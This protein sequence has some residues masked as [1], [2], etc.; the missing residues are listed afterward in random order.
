MTSTRS[1]LVLGLAVLF[2]AAQ[3]PAAAEDSRDGSVQSSIVP[4]MRTH[5]VRCHSEKVAMAGV[6]FDSVRDESAVVNAP[7]LW[8]TALQ[9]IRSG[10]MPP[11]GQ[12]RPSADSILA[13]SGWIEARLNRASK[14]MGKDPGRVTARRLN[15]VEYNNTVRDLTGLALRPADDFPADDSGYGFDNIGDVLSISPLL[16]EKYLAAARR[17]VQAA[18][19]DPAPIRP[20]AEKYIA[21]RIHAGESQQPGMNVNRRGEFSVKVQFPHDAQYTAKVRVQDRRYHPN[22]SEKGSPFPAPMPMAVL[23]DGKPLKTFQIEYSYSQ[24]SFDATFETT[25]GPHVLSTEF[26]FDGEEPLRVNIPKCPCNGELALF[27]DSVAVE[28]P[29]HPKTPRVSESYRKVFVCGHKRG[30]HNPRCTDA[31]LRN[32]AARAY[33]RPPSEIEIADLKRLAGVAEKNGDSF[34]RGIQLAMKAVLVSPHFLFRIERDSETS[35]AS[36]VHP[37]NPYEL[38]S[39]LSYFLW[40]SMPDEELIRAAR[41]S[42]LRDPERLRAQIGR[43]LKDDRSEALVENFAGQWLQLR[44]LAQ[45][46]PDPKT[47][48]EFDDSLRWAMRRETELFFKAVMREDRGILDFLD[49]KFSWVN[50][51]LA[52][53]YGIRGVHGDEFQ[54]VTLDGDQRSGVLTQASILTISS[55]PT[56]TSPVLRGKWILEN[57]LGSAPPPPPPGIPE[58]DTKEAGVAA[59]LRQK[60]EQHRANPS[61]AVCHQKM[62]ALGFGLE[63]YNAIGAW[64]TRDGNFDVDS[65]GELPGGITFKTPAG[66]KTALR[67]Q[68]DEFVRCF[69]E[70]M[71]TYALGRGLERY[72]R[73]AIDEIIGKAAP[74][75]YRFSRLIEEVVLSLPFQMRRGSGARP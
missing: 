40:S 13:V 51:R 26:R 28:G 37:V 5:C 27:V 25:A 41:M 56:R 48:P 15:R 12:A 75:Q 23:L 49:A 19:G 55:Y 32:L 7:Q 36:A 29:Y 17:T 70:K 39:R 72:D 65:S 66:M 24:G 11:P 71:L 52:D 3:P 16:M 18:I 31:V 2:L 22:Y 21:P 20:K 33:R 59:S 4:F 68:K 44:N 58:L 50:G 69:T 35:S 38:A 10:Q 54:R 60:L 30:E 46:K 42:E 73:P 53:H 47:F 1:G 67:G 9:K 45:A 34:D 8:E 6:R 64:R 63:N 74:D 62:D 57:L 43:M 61:C 14:A